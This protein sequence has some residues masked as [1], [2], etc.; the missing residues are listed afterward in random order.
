MQLDA[1]E[2]GDPFFKSHPQPS[3]VE[4]SKGDQVAQNPTASQE[5]DVEAAATATIEQEA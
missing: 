1:E 5:N 3:A 2:G 4:S